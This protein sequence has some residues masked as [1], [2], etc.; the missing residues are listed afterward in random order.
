MDEGIHLWD[1]LAKS[2][3][4]TNQWSAIHIKMLKIHFIEPSFEEFVNKQF[5]KIQSFPSISITHSELLDISKT[6]LFRKV[7][8]IF[9]HP[10][11][12]ML[13]LVFLQEI[14]T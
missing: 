3:W 12:L 2:S 5:K 7:L 4:I 10:N 6:V 8:C 9:H 13:L 14:S 11:K 1:M